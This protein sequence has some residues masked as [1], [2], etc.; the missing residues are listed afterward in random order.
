[1]IFL[2]QAFDGVI[3][4]PP[5]LQ[6]LLLFLAA[7]EFSDAVEE[8][9]IEDVIRDRMI[10]HLAFTR[11]VPLQVPQVLYLEFP[12]VLRTL[13]LVTVTTVCVARAGVLDDEVTGFTGRVAIEITSHESVDAVIGLLG[14]RLRRYHIHV[15]I[16]SPNPVDVRA[17]EQIEKN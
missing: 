17:N 4:E 6:D 1:M 12:P 11:P 13:V 14:Y 3:V 7:D 2:R 10:G 8:I 16:F 5:V 9:R 15:L